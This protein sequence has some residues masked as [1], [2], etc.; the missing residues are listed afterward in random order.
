MCCW[1][2]LLMAPLLRV[3]EL[4]IYYDG[5]LYWLWHLI[6]TSTRLLT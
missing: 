1:L 2:V 6:L 4:D 3:T 5:I